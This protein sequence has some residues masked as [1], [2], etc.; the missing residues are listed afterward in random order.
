MH[1][2]HEPSHSHRPVGSG[3]TRKALIAA[4]AIT[5]GF[6]VVEI[7]G[8][9]LSNSLALLADAGHMVSDVGALS[10]SLLAMA[11]AARPHT[12]DRT[13]GFHRMEVL[14]A[15]VNAAALLI[16]AFYVAFEAVGRLSDPEEVAG[17]SMLTVAAVGLL[18]NLVALALLRGHRHSSLNIRGAFLHVIGDALGSAGAIL[19]ALIILT[20]GWTRADSAVSLFIAALIVVSSW[21]LIRETASVLLEYSPKGLNVDAVR[22]ELEGISG[23]ENVHDLHVWTV[24]SGFNALSCHTRVQGG[25]DR[26]QVVRDATV[27]LRER[28]GITHATIQAE[29]SLVH[30]GDDPCCYDEHQQAGEAAGMRRA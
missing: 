26:D 17:V 8:G 24:T 25:T 9:V 11:F 29:A 20:T 1:D 27:L 15:F 5:S 12:S 2:H 21:R 13:F 3:A 19:A 30:G 28:Y 23:V 14:A 7:V 16:I 10:L 22:G 4:L 6:M 18:V